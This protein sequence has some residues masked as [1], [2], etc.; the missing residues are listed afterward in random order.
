MGISTW[1]AGV[2]V[3]WVT[4]IEDTSALTYDFHTTHGK[5]N[6]II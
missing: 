3:L 1:R 2:T 4:F 6:V 5:T